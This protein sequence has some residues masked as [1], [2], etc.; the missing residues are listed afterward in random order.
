ML[1]RKKNKKVY[2]GRSFAILYKPKTTET[3]TK[4]KKLM[5]CNDFN[6][7]RLIKWLK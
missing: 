5:V 3:E 4:Q 6:T 1:L 2:I 7:S